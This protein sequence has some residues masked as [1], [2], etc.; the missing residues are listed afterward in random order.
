MR[1]VNY[2]MKAFTRTLLASRLYQ[3]SSDTTPSNVDD[4]QNFSHFTYKA[5]P[6]EVLLDA[7]AQATGVPEQYEGW[8]SASRDTNLGQPPAVVLL[9]H[10]RPPDSP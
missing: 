7:I 4:L 9:P 5:M 1:D 8:R 2:D 6:A 3:L 10:L